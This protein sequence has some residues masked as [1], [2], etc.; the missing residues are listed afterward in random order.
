MATDKDFEVESKV[1]NHPGFPVTEF[2]VTHRKTGWLHI[3]YTTSIAEFDES[4]A[5]ER[6]REAY[7][8][9]AV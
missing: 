8:N 3:S 9:E 6:A 7:R 4:D 5:L 2:R 1:V